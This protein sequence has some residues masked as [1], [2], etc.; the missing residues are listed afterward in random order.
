MARVSL[1]A[2]ADLIAHVRTLEG[3]R[4]VLERVVAD[5]NR[6]I[7]LLVGEL[8]RARARIEDLEGQASMMPHWICRA[9]C[10]FNGEAKERLAFCRCC[11]A[12]RP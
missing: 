11:G 3:T 12:A 8:R 9:C 2:V 4:A 5:K 7:A 1:H 6:T 10:A